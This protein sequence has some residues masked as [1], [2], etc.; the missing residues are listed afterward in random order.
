MGWG[1]L[2]EGVL[3]GGC[4]GCLRVPPTPGL[5]RAGLMP[6]PVIALGVLFARCPSGRPEEIRLQGK[7]YLNFFCQKKKC[8]QR[9]LHLTHGKSKEI[10]RKMVNSIIF[11][12]IEQESEVNFRVSLCIML[13]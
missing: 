4:G 3:E 9:N 5:P 10:Y 6:P 8:R 13:L 2:R 1:E 11:R 12:L 7:K